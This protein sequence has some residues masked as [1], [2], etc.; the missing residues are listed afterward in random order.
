MAADSAPENTVGRLSLYRRILEDLRR[1]G[2]R[3]VYS[4]ELAI[5]AAGTAAQVR[6]DIMTIGHSGS[7]SRGYGVADL[8]ESIEVFLDGPTGQS[9]VVVGAGNLGRAI[10]AYVGSRRRKLTI[11]A[12][13][14]ADPAKT[15]RVVQGVRCYSIE[16][17]PDVVR[18]QGVRVGVI[19]VPGG[20]SQAVASMLVQA[21]IRGILNFAPVRLRVPPWVYVEDLDVT[22]SLEKVAY[23]ARMSRKEKDGW[24]GTP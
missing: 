18:E 21:G 24:H 12:A 3:S 15:D 7:P 22:T 6:R 8:I 17:L 20:E 10:M 5:L 1:D 16:R 13:F 23:F 11:V 14:D 9:V 4:H 19:A 2:K